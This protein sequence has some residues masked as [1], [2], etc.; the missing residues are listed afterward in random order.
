MKARGAVINH[1]LTNDLLR[2]PKGRTRAAI[3]QKRIPV[4]LSGESNGDPKVKGKYLVDP[5][6]LAEILSILEKYRDEHFNFLMRAG[7]NMDQA[8]PVRFVLHR[9]TRQPLVLIPAVGRFDE[10]ACR[11]IGPIAGSCFTLGCGYCPAS[12]LSEAHGS[13]AGVKIH[14]GLDQSTGEG[15]AIAMAGAVSSRDPLDCN[16]NQLCGPAFRVP[17][18]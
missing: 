15:M 4:R 6:Q 2:A 11:W 7:F 5:G 12:R 8:L 3:L 13:S 17:V 14:P 10:A 1:L 16:A 18:R 9:L